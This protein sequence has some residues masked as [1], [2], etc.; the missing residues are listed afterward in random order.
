MNLICGHAVAS[1]NQALPW[2]QKENI[3]RTHPQQTVVWQDGLFRWKSPP[4][5]P[6]F[7]LHLSCQGKVQPRPWQGQS[8]G[9]GP[10]VLVNIKA[11]FFAACAVC[12]RPTELLHPHGPMFQGGRGANEQ[13][14]C[15]S[16]R[17]RELLCPP[18][19]IYRSIF[20]MTNQLLKLLQ[21]F[22]VPSP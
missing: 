6:M 17:E 5:F 7:H 15:M 16:L 8:K 21:T 4:G 18:R 10:E 2:D 13:G 11:Y 22:D 19:V 12:C 20:K 9:Q 1:E 14:N 3:P